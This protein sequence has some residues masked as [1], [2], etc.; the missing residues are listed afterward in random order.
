MCAHII[1]TS[2]IYNLIHCLFN[3]NSSLDSIPAGR[4]SKKLAKPLSKQSVVKLAKSSIFESDAE[5]DAGYEEDEQSDTSS[6]SIGKY[7]N[8]QILIST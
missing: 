4:K 8:T 7:Q 3:R 5:E 2:V 1:S 6:C